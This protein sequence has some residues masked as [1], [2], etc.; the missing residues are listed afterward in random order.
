MIEFVWHVWQPTSL[1]SLPPWM[2]SVLVARLRGGALVE[3]TKLVKA[4]TSG[5]NG[6][7]V[8]GASSGS[9]TVSK[10]ATELPFEVGSIAD[11]GLVIPI[12]FR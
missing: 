6:W 12:S 5:P 9:G 1:N 11:S 4:S 10:A 7:A 3:R 2:M 8:V